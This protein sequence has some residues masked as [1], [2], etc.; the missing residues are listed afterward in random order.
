VQ[1][2]ER[3]VVLNELRGA[4]ACATGGEG[5]VVLVS[6]E[7]GIGKT[8]VVRAF[9][10]GLGATGPIRVLRGACDDLVTPRTLGPFHD[11]AR[12]ANPAVRAALA[13][14]AADAVFDALLDE[15][16]IATTVLIVE[17][18]HW[19]DEATLGVLAFLARRLE[20]SP[21]ML[22]LTYRDNEVPQESPLQRLLGTV[23]SLVGVRVTLEPLSARGVT[24][25]AG[26]HGAGLRL[27]ASTGGNP[28]FVTELLAAQ[29]E[30]LPASV[31]DAVLAR[32]ASL[33][34]PARA[35]LDLLAVVPGRLEAELLNVLHPS[36]VQDAGPAERR[37]IVEMRDGALAFRHEL[38]RQAVANALPWARRHQLGHAVLDALLA[39]EPVDEAR[40]LHH[41]VDC[42]DADVIIR[43]GP[44][45]ARGAA[46]AGAHQQAL[47]HYEQLR[48]HTGLLG[49]A[50]R[51]AVTEEHAWELFYNAHRISDAVDMSRAAVQLWSEVG[52]PVR[53]GR[54]HVTLAWHLYLN[55]D[56]AEAG[57][58]VTRAVALLDSTGDMAARAL[59]RSYRGFLLV[60]SDREEQGLAELEVAQELVQQSGTRRLR[61]ACVSYQGLG[62]AFLGDVEGLQLLQRGI[63]EAAA[64]GQREFVALG[65]TSLVKA[66]R[67]FGCD[68]DVRR[69]AEEGLAYTQEWDF[70][71]HGYALAAHLYQ[72]LA[73]E[74]SWDAAEAGL[75]KLMASVPEPGILGRETL[76]HLGRL[77]MRRGHPDAV[78]LLDQAWELAVSADI[79]P[80][81]VPAGLAHIERA[82][83]AGEPEPEWDRATLLLERTNRPGAT[84]YRGE[85]LRYV[86][87]CGW[88]VKEFAGCRPE[89][90]LGLRG[91]WA[92][93]A[94]AWR[95][96]G[97]PYEQALELADSGQAK[98]TLE[99]L[100]LLDDLGAEPAARIV[101]AR[102]RALGVTRVPRGPREATREH[103]AGLTERQADVLAML[104]D[105]LTN[106]EIAARLV[107]SVRTVDHHVS[108][109]L[110]KLG[111][112][113]RRDAAR[114]AI[115]LR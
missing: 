26:D 100:R 59:A 41:A 5:R 72:L 74:G 65:Y 102:L 24:Q 103:P 13:A 91:D 22:L 53:L 28:F 62:R 54:A 82:W 11:M 19:A 58:V 20:R 46:R 97:D 8:S 12:R 30:G 7:A 44:V 31:R 52:E 107:V 95:R 29:D 14:D 71:S 36:W 10:A 98:P 83:L 32:A 47:A 112:Q 45:A 4:L 105:G 48:P 92:G 57:S 96:L 16:A 1:L 106:A 49:L 79:L 3:D 63:A 25:L 88:P 104:G 64:D 86:K 84:R 85:L 75:R 6:G 66:L 89:H 77:L 23:S 115:D 55:A 2:L 94:E 76:P 39:R 101:R 70:R 81:L 21:A 37:G 38:S 113:N 34:E 51:A 111:V 17:D 73:Q 27:H 60:L 40:V 18:V 50:D 35:L 78:P 80:V 67:R 69:Y 90:A 114:A 33:A 110:A 93:A 15:L 43:F 99:A 42:G 108:A 87:R 61:A 56:V 68:A 9:L 109:I